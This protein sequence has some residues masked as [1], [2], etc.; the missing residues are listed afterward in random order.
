M[1]P[2]LTLD[3]NIYP[4]PRNVTQEQLY[5]LFAKAQQK[6][7]GHDDNDDGPSM[8]MLG[9]QFAN[10]YLQPAVKELWRRTER[11]WNAFCATKLQPLQEYERWCDADIRE[12]NR[13]AEKLNNDKDPWY[14]EKPSDSAIELTRREA[15]VDL[16]EADCVWS[17]EWMAALAVA[18]GEAVIGEVLLTGSDSWEVVSTQDVISVRNGDRMFHPSA[19]GKAMIVQR[20]ERDGRAYKLLFDG[21]PPTND[22]KILLLPAPPNWGMATTLIQNTLNKVTKGRPWTHYADVPLEKRPGTVPMPADIVGQIEASR[23][24]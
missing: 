22:K 21:Q 6:R 2:Q 5:G 20:M 15:L 16:F 14:E 12:M 3:S 24:Q 4:N 10:K 17:D 8:S 1:E 13:V 11:A 9:Q 19:F 23:A 7:R 18:D